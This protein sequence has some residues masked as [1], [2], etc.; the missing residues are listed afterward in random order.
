MLMHNKVEPHGEYSDTGRSGS[1]FLPWP[2]RETLAIDMTITEERLAQ[3]RMRLEQTVEDFQDLVTEFERL[4]EE[5]LLLR[6]AILKHAQASH[7]ACSEPTAADRELHV[8]L[9]NR[10]RGDL[11]RKALL[12]LAAARQFMTAGRDG[13]EL[14]K[15]ALFAAVRNFDE[16]SGVGSRPSSSTSV[17]IRHV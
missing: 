16:A 4:Q 2:I 9:H 14:N 10:P 7:A 6:D 17:P 12:V 1:R 11:N 15:R 3:I 5:N 13:E 8:A